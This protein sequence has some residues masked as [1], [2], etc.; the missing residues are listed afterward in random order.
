MIN[1]KVHIDG[2]LHNISYVFQFDNSTLKS[3]RICLLTLSFFNCQMWI[4][5]NISFHDTEIY[6]NLECHI[7][8][9]KRLKSSLYFLFEIATNL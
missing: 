5:K 6:L 2:L 3:F 8:L 1:I 4:L 7:T 9:K